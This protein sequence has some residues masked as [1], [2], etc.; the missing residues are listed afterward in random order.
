MPRME[1]DG[2]FLRAVGDGAPSR[3]SPSFEERWFVRPWLSASAAAVEAPLL[4]LESFV[5]SYG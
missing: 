3:G 1:R 2:A 4:L 5:M